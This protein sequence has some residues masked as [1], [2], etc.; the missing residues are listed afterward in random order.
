MEKRECKIYRK[1][2]S[3]LFLW[4]ASYDGNKATI[5]QKRDLPEDG[6]NPCHHGTEWVCVIYADSGCNPVI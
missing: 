4:E 2:D 5:V 6:H 1:I 3:R